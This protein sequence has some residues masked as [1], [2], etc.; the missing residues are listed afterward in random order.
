MEGIEAAKQTGQS[1]GDDDLVLSIDFV[2]YSAETLINL[3]RDISA[4]IDDVVQESVQG[5]HAPYEGLIRIR[6]LIRDTTEGYEWLVPLATE[7]EKDRE[8]ATDLR[9]RFRNVQRSALKEFQ[10]SLKDIISPKQ[11][12]FHIRGYRLE[13]LVKGVMVD[14]S[15]GIFGLYTVD[16][17]RDPEGWDYSGHAVTMCPCDK[18]GDFVQ[19][20]CADFF[21]RWFELLW[22]NNQF[23]KSLDA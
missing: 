2:A 12:D 9:T 6:I 1:P 23:T 4:E 19:A 13:P 17:L 11:V 16:D 18:N 7:H 5:A 8:Y 15:K 10:E 3:S 14:R 22:D 20:T 21:R